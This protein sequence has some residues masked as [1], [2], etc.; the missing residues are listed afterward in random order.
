MLEGTTDTIRE[1][2]IIYIP[3][4]QNHSLTNT[5]DQPFEIFEICAP[6]GDRFDFVEDD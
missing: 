6:A 3:A 5:G 4:G 2:G 1:D